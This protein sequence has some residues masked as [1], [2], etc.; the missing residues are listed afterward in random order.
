M[1][2]TLKRTIKIFYI[3][4]FFLLCI[5][6]FVGM[7]FKSEDT[8]NTE[9]RTLSSPPQLIVDGG[10]ND[11]FGSDA[12]TYVSEHFGFRNTLISLNSAIYYDVFKQSNQQDVIVGTNGWLYYTPTL[13]DYLNRDALSDNE[14]SCIVRT[15]E[16]QQEYVLS[17]GGNYVFA[18]VPNKNTLYPQGMPSRYIKS[19]EQNTLTKLTNALSSTDIHYC[20]LKDVLSAQDSILYH[21]DDTHWNNHGALVGYNA[22]L[23][24]ANVP[25]NDYSTVSFNSV[26]SWS[27]DLATMLSPNSTR[28]DYQIEYDIDY[29]YQYTSRLRTDNLD[30]ITITTANS[31]AEGSLL[32]FRDSFGRAIL[33]FMAENFN[34]AEFSRA[35]PYN[36]STTDADLV[37]QEIVER[38]IVNLTKSAPI[39]LAPKRLNVTIPEQVISNDSN[40]LQCNINQGLEAVKLYGKV[41]C[42]LQDYSNIHIYVVVDGVNTY[43][44]FP[45]FEQELLSDYTLNNDEVG[46]S[47]LVPQEVAK[48]GSTVEVLLYSNDSAVSTT[49]ILGTITNG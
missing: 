27:G 36:L 10:I 39:M 1:N 2:N 22:I 41:S 7:F 43:E 9:N 13:N 6:P 19:N 15:L 42:N 26:K 17:Y 11:S 20:N 3:V 24:Y 49:G 23:D 34:S 35:M 38:N 14:I 44:A 46:Y 40:L 48:E 12:E 45:I 37:V 18:V 31:S 16:L 28:L 32:M 8:S 4:V 30:D 47:L 25:H 29:N 33:P 21:K 5:L